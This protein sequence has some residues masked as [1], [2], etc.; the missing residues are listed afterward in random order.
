MAEKCPALSHECRGTRNRLSQLRLESF[1]QPK[2]TILKN[3]F[4]W[5]LAAGT[6]GSTT[7]NLRP[8]PAQNT[9]ATATLRRNRQIIKDQGSTDSRRAKHFPQ[10]PESSQEVYERCLVLVFEDVAGLAV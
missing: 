8:L 2:S 1:P 5:R 9:D 7:D 3:F 6:T 4:R 10:C